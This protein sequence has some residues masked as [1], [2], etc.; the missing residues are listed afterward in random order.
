MTDAEHYLGELVKSLAKKGGSL[1]FSVDF[2][3]AK[4]EVDKD[5]EVSL[6]DEFHKLDQG[7]REKLGVPASCT[8]TE[9]MLAYIE[10]RLVDRQLRMNE[11]EV[12]ERHVKALFER[13]GSMPLSELILYVRGLFVIEERVEEKRVVL[14][15]ERRKT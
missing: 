12:L 11:H 7:I 2:G 4:A 15:L 10:K 14:V 6:A 9:E 3:Q 5:L 13:E 1:S 8:T